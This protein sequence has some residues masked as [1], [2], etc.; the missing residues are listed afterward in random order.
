[1][2]ALECVSLVLTYKYVCIIHASVQ[3]EYAF[4]AF[5]LLLMQQNRSNKDRRQRDTENVC[6]REYGGRVETINI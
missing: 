4:P 6:R 3:V 5:N 2:C 1:M